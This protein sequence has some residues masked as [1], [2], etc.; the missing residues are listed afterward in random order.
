MKTTRENW[1]ALVPAAKHDAVADALRSVFGST[2]IRDVSRL[3]GGGSPST[4]LR[5]EM[6]AKCY[7][8][9]VVLQTHALNDPARHYACL[10][11]AAEA[12]MAPRVHYTNAAEPILR[13]KMFRPPTRFRI[14]STR[15]L[16]LRI[17]YPGRIRI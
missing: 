9:R 10:E 14:Y 5:F 16:L 11:A 3:T 17:N 15:I 6:S 1:K 7:V 8:M 12:G 2:N 13:A 4:V